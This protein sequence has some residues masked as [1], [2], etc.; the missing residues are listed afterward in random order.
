MKTLYYILYICM[1]KQT[2]KCVCMHWMTKAKAPGRN[3]EHLDYCQKPS[4]CHDSTY[5]FYDTGDQSYQ[6]F[7]MGEKKIANE[8]EKRMSAPRA[9]PPLSFPQLNS[10]PCLDRSRRCVETHKESLDNA[11]ATGW[12]HH[13]QESG[14]LVQTADVQEHR[15]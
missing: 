10:Q 3:H 11:R 8:G 14:G 1:S 15:H 4:P 7:Q 2:L 12:K 5:G 13:K 6:G 9:T